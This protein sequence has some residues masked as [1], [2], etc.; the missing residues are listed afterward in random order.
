[1]DYWTPQPLLIATPFSIWKVRTSNLFCI[2]RFISINYNSL[3][4]IRWY[5]ILAI[6]AIRPTD[7]TCPISPTPMKPIADRAISAYIHSSLVDCLLYSLQTTNVI[8]TVVNQ[9][10]TQYVPLD[11]R[12]YSS[13]SSSFYP[14]SIMSIHPRF[15]FL[16]NV[17]FIPLSAI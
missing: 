2:Y 15:S 10:V 5:I 11:D 12:K 7:S 6:G 4:Y 3:L 8:D 17:Y 1:M 14:Y 9:L 16:V 13:S